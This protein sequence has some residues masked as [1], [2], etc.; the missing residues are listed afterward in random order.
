MDKKRGKRE[1][2][3]PILFRRI[4]WSFHFISRSIYRI[5]C[6]TKNSQ[7]FKWRGNIRIL[8]ILH[9]RNDISNHCH[10]FSI[11]NRSRWITIS[12]DRFSTGK[13]KAA[14]W[15]PYAQAWTYLTRTVSRFVNRTLSPFKYNAVT[16]C[17]AIQFNINSI[18]NLSLKHCPKKFMR[19]R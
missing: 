7:G 4:P 10:L 3:D 15:I 5:S 14:N 16:F 17:V 11:V 13:T 18:G 12:K 19:F 2:G 8:T 9:L 6:T 1:H